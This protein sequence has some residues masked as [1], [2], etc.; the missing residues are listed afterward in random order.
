[1]GKMDDPKR[2]DLAGL[3]ER[4]TRGG[5][6]EQDLPENPLQLFRQWIEEAVKASVAESN[7]MSLSTVKPDGTPDARMVLLKGI[8]DGSLLFFTNYDSEKSMDLEKHPHAAGCM[9]WPELERQIRFVGPVEKLA[10]TDSEE[11]FARR[12]RESQIGAWASRQSKPIES[13]DVLQRRVEEM[14]KR[15]EGSEV[16][17]PEQWGGYRILARRFEFW[18]GR[19]GRLHDRIRYLLRQDARWKFERLSP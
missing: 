2:V 10:R 18:Q 14:E 4:Y 3:R 12:P 17:C 16:P 5:L 19:P 13:R 8:E 9:W 6:L 15:F 7:A 1:M 11:Y